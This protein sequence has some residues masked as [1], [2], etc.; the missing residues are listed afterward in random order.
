MANG[1]V[2]DFF[3]RV[4][5]K[6]LKKGT[7]EI[8]HFASG[9]K[10]LGVTIGAAFAAQKIIAFSKASLSAFVADDKAAKILAKSLDNL[11]LSY[12][13]PEVKNFISNLET[14]TGVLDD[15][16]RPA[17]Q[18]LVTTTADWRKSQDLL[19]TAL[20]LSAM[21]G[22][23]VVS[24]ADDLARA[25]AGNTKGLNKYGL[26]LTKTQLQAMSFEQILKQI[27]K[28]SSGQAQIAADSYAGSLDK[29]NVAAKNA[30]E[31]IGKGLVQALTEVSGA[32]GFEGALAGIN[33]FSSGIADA[34][35]GTGRLIKII[36][37]FRESKGG[38]AGAYREVAAFNKANARSDM[39]SRQQFGGPA[40][41]KYKAAADKAAELKLLK[42]ANALR[43]I[44]NKSLFDKLQASK[45][46]KI[47]D[48]LKKRNDVER[49]G[50]EYALTQATTESARLSIKSQLDIMDG[51]AKAAAEDL[52]AQVKMAADK[53]AAEQRAQERLDATTKA[54]EALNINT[55]AL[56][57]TIDPL[58]IAFTGLAIATD[59]L[60]TTLMDKI[61]ALNEGE[62][63]A[64]A[65]VRPPYASPFNPSLSAFGGKLP[66]PS[67]SHHDFGTDGGDMG[68]IN[69]TGT[70][71]GGKTYS[72]VAGAVDEVQAI[73]DYWAEQTALTL[74]AMADNIANTP[75][76]LQIYG[77]LNDYGFQYAVQ[78]ANQ[79]N[80]RAGVSVSGTA[81][82]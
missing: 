12:A 78:R 39:L 7:K 79:A 80:A 30:Q 13:N 41:E 81:S 36:G 72:V 22:S 38:F 52:A 62:T 9:V 46:Q 47:L 58:G 75:I 49:I 68:P 74:A 11:G 21:S 6:A 34:I 77:D 71:G 53:A 16:L 20:D 35:I 64:A 50:L 56:T 66:A 51:N 29:L 65:V 57:A 69:G 18:K 44:E 42:N 82:T 27:A 43:A 2:F 40:A 48:D 67:T 32:N 1:V 28:V 17:F 4:D 37:I 70:D 76:E 59:A 14:Q 19:K 45:D 24:V 60:S 61:K 73:V 26:G 3:T 55:E 63:H 5:T 8:N 31:T 33:A 25:Y 23:D 10:K 54:F 15:K